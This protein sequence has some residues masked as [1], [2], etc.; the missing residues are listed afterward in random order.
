MADHEPALIIDSVHKQFLLPHIKVNSLKEIVV[1]PFRK[2]KSSEVHHAL[3]GISFTVGKGE[4]LGVVGRNGSGKSTLLKLIAETYQPTKGS[5]TV[6]GSLVPFIELGVGFNPELTGRDNVYLNGALLGFGRKKMTSMYDDIVEFAELED[7]MD[8]KLKNFSSGMQVRLAFSIAIRAESDILLLDEVLA[9]GDA[10]FQKKCFDYFRLLKENKR[11]V[12]LVSHSMDAIREYC[13]RAI[14]IEGGKVMSEGS[15]QDIAQ[16]YLKLFV[17]RAK[18]EESS[19]RWGSEAAEILSCNVKV[20]S[21]KVYVVTKYKA[22]EDL[23]DPILGF[24]ISNEMGQRIIEANTKKSNVTSGEIKK[25]QY[26]VLE[27][28]VPNI[29]LNGHYDISPAV[30]DGSGLEVFEWWNKAI[31]FDVSEKHGS[32]AIVEPKNEMKIK[33]G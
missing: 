1:H 25:N 20:E 5:V 32:G 2:R 30:T 14:L 27:A 7:Y 6:N 17:N 19:Q 18:K 13:D 11:T 10:S 29:F 24:Q 23:T 26:I 28:I 9:V 8:Q 21:E 12:I 3:N 4:F 15:P 33:K 16:D 31:S 22:N